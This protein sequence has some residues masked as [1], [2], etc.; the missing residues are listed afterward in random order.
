MIKNA[1]D[2]LSIGKVLHDK[3]FPKSRKN[4]SVRR[5]MYITTTVLIALLITLVFFIDK[6]V[7]KI[8][9]KY[10]LES[11]V[12]ETYDC[13][14]V[15]GAMVYQNSVPSAMLVDRLN[16]AL[17]IYNKKVVNKIIVSGDHGTKEYDE[18]NTMRTYLINRGIPSEDIFMDHAGFDTY[19]TI[20]RARDVFRV[21]KALIATQDYH[22]LRALYIGQKLSVDLHGIDSTLRVYN[23][24]TKNR[25]REYFARVK[26]FIECEVTKPKPKY[27][28]DYIPIYGDG[29]QTVD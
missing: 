22:L 15:P 24:E 16:V 11:D 17:E 27:L 2:S 29:N 23:N 5:I 13:I 19:Q 1:N 10:I 26:A 18:V 3:T 25:I 21:K 6:R 14:I 9:K 28:G 20:Y 12:V 4:G 7:E 8:G